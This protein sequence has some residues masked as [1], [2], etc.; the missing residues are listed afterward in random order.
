MHRPDAAEPLI[1]QLRDAQ[2]GHAILHAGADRRRDGRGLLIDL[3][4]HEV[5]VA[6]LFG[7]FLIP[8]RGQALALHGL[9]KGVVEPDAL[10]RH[11]S[12]VAFFQHAVIPGVL[13]QGRDI[14]GHKVF[15]LA[16]AHDEG[17][18]FF[19]GE[20]GVREILEQ[21][22]Q[23]IAAPHHAQRLVQGLQRLAMVAAV[24]EFD[25][26]LGVRLTLKR[27]PPGGQPLLESTVIFNDAIVDDAHPRGRVRVAVHIAGFP[28]GRPP[29]VPDAAGA[30]REGLY[31]QF[32]AQGIQ[33]ALALDNA[34]AALLGQ[35]HTRRIIP[36]VL[37]FLQTIQQHILCAALSNIT[38]DA[39]HTKHLHTDS[40]AQPAHSTTVS[41]LYQF[42]FLYGFL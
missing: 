26:Y 36:A 42:M 25:Q 41:F 11:D 19:H 8:V 31:G 38:Y 18:L 37:Q 40:P 24:N 5:G 10:G 14:R 13:E 17:A 9:P 28:V 27:V 30:L 6:A 32:L 12:Q 23:R 15:A 4:E 20:D 29:G 2:V 16:P 39:A 33:P 21:H 22:G 1:R 7:R 34:D 35:C 3:L